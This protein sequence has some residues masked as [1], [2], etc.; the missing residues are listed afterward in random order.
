MERQGY[1]GSSALTMSDAYFPEGSSLLFPL[2][3]TDHRHLLRIRFLRGT[4]DG[5]T[6]K[7]EVL[8]DEDRVR[9]EEGDDGGER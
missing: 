6:D 8:G 4:V 1:L 2:C 7:G 5:I 3:S 9:R